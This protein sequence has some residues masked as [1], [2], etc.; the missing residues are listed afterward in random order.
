MTWKLPP[1]MIALASAEL[2]LQFALLMQNVVH[3]NWSP[4]SGQDEFGEHL[5]G[6]GSQ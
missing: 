4:N 2:T 5:L 1:S 6:W 3:A